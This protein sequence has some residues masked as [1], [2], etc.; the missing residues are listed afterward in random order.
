MRSVRVGVVANAP[1]RWPTSEKLLEVSRWL[2]SQQSSWRTPMSRKRKQ[3]VNTLVQARTQFAGIGTRKAKL[4]LNKLARTD[5]YAG[6]L[7]T[8]L[9]IEDANLTA[10]RYFGGNCGGLSYPEIHY[11]KKRQSIE[12]LIEIC[13]SQGWVFGVQP[14]GAEMEAQDTG[15]SGPEACRRCNGTGICD[16]GGGYKP[17]YHQCDKCNGSGKSKQAIQTRQQQTHVI[18]FDIPGVGQV[19]WHYSPREPL[20][21][22]QGQWDGKEGSTLPKLEAAISVL[23]NEVVAA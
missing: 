14:T 7:R 11:Q 21:I 19:S 3:R 18:Y 23:L 20:P 10:K 17:D 16:Y 12:V 8:A 5:V 22:Y 1:Q 4:A 2:Q 6:A 13:T 15:P 9:E